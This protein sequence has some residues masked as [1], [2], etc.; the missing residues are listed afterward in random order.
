MKLLLVGSGGREASLAWKISEEHS[1]E[2]CSI[3]ALVKHENPTIL[4]AS[5]RTGGAVHIADPENKNEVAAYA[6]KAGV[7]LVFV[8]ADSPLEAGVIDPIL[9]LGIPAV[10]PTRSGAEIEW[11]K[12]YSRSLLQSVCSEANPFFKIAHSKKEVESLFADLPSIEVAVKPAGLT[13]GKGV[14]V[15]GP[16]LE[17]LEDAKKY[18]LSIF[19]EAIGNVPAVI[20]EEKIS[21]I[22]FTLQ[23]FTDGRTIIFPQATYD[24]PYRFDGDTG[25]G[26]G[27][28]G[29]YTY[30]KNE[31]PFLTSA[32]YQEACTITE[33]IL[34]AHVSSGRDFSGILYSS[35]FLTP[36]G[37][38]KV[39]E[40]NARFGDPECM[41][42]MLL[43]K[44]N[45]C[46]I[47]Q[48]IA[49]KTLSHEDVLFKQEASLVTYLV[50]PDYA[51]RSGP[52]YDFTIDV[53]G[54]EEHFSGSEK[55]S[56]FFSSAVHKEEKKYETV[57]N[58][59]VVALGTAS[60]KLEHA[61][62]RIAQCIEKYCSGPLERRRD[63]GS[64]E[65]ISRICRSI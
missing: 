63:I 59:R 65:N 7:D 58:S 49:A 21:G 61:Y 44:S 26:T 38:L 6:K 45:L 48:K 22:E 35:F 52:Q 16:H 20:I 2:P 4:N 31:L 60:P 8:S 15:M 64:E 27:G 25:P 46:T 34:K 3:Y 9:E 47:L 13:A 41:N 12:V 42:I 28:M 29:S 32:Q 62:A 14:K 11:N 37:K 56:V 23:C 1:L 33:K 40:F 19:D 39:V 43:L 51:L 5:K 18:A 57:G 54:I 55:V 30:G 36:E 10:G 50:S 17:S 24:Y 53:K